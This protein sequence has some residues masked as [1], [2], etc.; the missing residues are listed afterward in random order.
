MRQLTSLWLVAAD[1]D[2]VST[3][4]AG[5]SFPRWWQQELSRILYWSHSVSSWHMIRRCLH[6]KTTVLLNGTVGSVHTTRR[7]F[8][9][10]HTSP[11]GY[12]DLDLPKFNLLVPGSQVYDW[13]SLVTI[14]L[15]LAPGSC[16][17]TNLYIYYLHTRRCWR[18]HNLP[19]LSVREVKTVVKLLQMEHALLKNHQVKDIMSFIVIQITCEY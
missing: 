8:S 15:E 17:Q 12:T 11:S 13:P 9:R 10:A 18:K 7:A 6:N 1:R 2:L 4:P 16:S 5:C 3:P 14:G 19:C